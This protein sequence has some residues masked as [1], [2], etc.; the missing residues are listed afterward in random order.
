MVVEHILNDRGEYNSVKQFII[1]YT[2]TNGLYKSLSI[3]MFKNFVF[4]EAKKVES[5]YSVYIGNIW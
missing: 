1:F 2:I 5:F 4:E 3:F